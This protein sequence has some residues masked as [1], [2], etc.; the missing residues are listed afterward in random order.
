MAKIGFKKLTLEN[1]FQADPIYDCF[2]KLS[3]RGEGLQM[4]AEDWIGPLLKPKL[5]K[6]VPQDVR[7]LFEVA[8]AGMAYGYF[9]YP[10]W[11][12]GV[13]QLF[14]VTEAAVSHKCKFLKA[15]KSKR[16]SADKIDWLENQ[17]AISSTDKDKLHYVRKLRNVT[18]HPERQQILPPGLV[19]PLLK[20]IALIVNSVFAI[21]LKTA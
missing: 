7:D 10:L 4:V 2:V 1:W 15:P 8:R 3:P 12:L 21:T 9:F 19:R 11:T 18:S 16:R 20:D 13:E 14:R 6:T 17:K 5:S